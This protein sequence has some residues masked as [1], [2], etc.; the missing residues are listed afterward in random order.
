M[1]TRER[2]HIS[3]AIGVLIVALLLG[4]TI[5]ASVL[6]GWTTVGSAGT[7]DEDSLSIVG[8]TGPTVGLK[9]RCLLWFLGL[10][11]P[12]SV[13]TGTVTVRYNIVPSGALYVTQASG[14]APFTLST[15]FRDTGNLQHVVLFLREVNLQSG[16]ENTLLTVDSD[17]F[18]PSLDYQTQ[19]GPSSC[20][21][22]FNFDQNAYYVEARISNSSSNS[23]PGLQAICINRCA[24]L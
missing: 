24:S 7:V 23:S 18:N 4:T 9:T 16:V 22:T 8:L 3:L 17:S 2:H 10:Q 6:T 5:G 12:C 11:W 19:T 1:K 15:R 20:A 21:F 13:A 14:F